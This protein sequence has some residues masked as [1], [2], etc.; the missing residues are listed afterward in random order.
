MCFVNKVETTRTSTASECAAMP[1]TVGGARRHFG[2]TLIELLV[3]AAI[4]SLLLAVLLPSVYS[5]RQAARRVECMNNMHQLIVGIRSLPEDHR[6]LGEREQA[7]A[8]LKEQRVQICP[9]DEQGAARLQSAGSSYVDNRPTCN[10]HDRIASSK[11]I[12][13][14]EAA[15]ACASR[16]VDPCKWFQ[17]STTS[18]V[19]SAVRTAIDI[20]RHGDVSNYAYADGHVQAIPASAIQAW[21]DQRFNFALRNNGE[22]NE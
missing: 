7:E 13:L 16:T 2:I 19:M 4:V 5:S 6:Y 18:K 20:Q 14:F 15:E 22:Y 9:M 10:N 1:G 21:V 11:T 12:V 3:V 17:A 8:M